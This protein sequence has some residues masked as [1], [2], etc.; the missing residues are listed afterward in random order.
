MAKG[1]MEGVA[2]IDIETTGT[3]PYDKGDKLLQVACIVT[4]SDLNIL[5]EQGINLIVKYSEEE[6]QELY[7][8]SVPFV[9]EMHKTTG[10]W[11][12]ITS[13][14]ALPLE[15]V[16]ELLY[17][18]LRKFYP[19]KGDLWFGG[20]SVYL[21]RSF[22]EKFAPKAYNHIHYRTVDVT[23][24]GGPARAWFG[25]EFEKKRSHD[26]MEDIMESINELRAY[27]KD[28]F[29]KKVG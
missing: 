11:N 13:G 6:A 16:D 21:D 15:T 29:V 18:Y 27:R 9:Q 2:W 1:E 19:E 24:F 23:S 12:R 20:N 25:Y 5:D 14:E 4:D 17:D 26:A 10:L 7:D 28:L 3:D 8:M 22:L